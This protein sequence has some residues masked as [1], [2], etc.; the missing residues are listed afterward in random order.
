[1]FIF[2]LYISIDR[3]ALTSFPK[4]ALRGDIFGK[5][6]Q[7]VLKFEFRKIS[8]LSLKWKGMVFV[9]S[10]YPTGSEISRFQMA[11]AR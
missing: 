3:Y 8:I 7:K 10:S 6:F 4:E 9:V 2:H 11:Q 5:A 1:M